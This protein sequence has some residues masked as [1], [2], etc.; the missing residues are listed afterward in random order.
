MSALR[1]APLTGAA[2]AAA[3]ADLARLRIAVFRDWP[4][5]YEGNAA[6]EEDYLRRYAES[7]GA[8]VVGAWAGDDLV[9]AATAAPLEDHAAEF[10]A[11]LRARGHDPA[12]MLYCGESVLLP[13][14]RGQGAGRAFFAQR[15]AHGRALGRRFACF[16]GVVRAADDPRRPRAYTPLDPFW[17]RCGYAPM[18]GVT[19]PFAWREIGSGAMQDHPMQFWIKPL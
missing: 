2:L 10:V 4:Y 8:L 16:C 18:P 9:G 11:A 17:R 13:A 3:L 5:L 6:Y 12:T 7:A 14:W 19:A 1:F 15:E